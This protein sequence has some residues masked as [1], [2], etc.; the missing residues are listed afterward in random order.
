[1]LD[2]GCSRFL[3]G[4]N[5]LEKWEQIPAQEGQAACASGAWTPL[6]LSKE[7]RRDLGCH[8]D[9]GRG[10]LSFEKLGVRAVVT[11][12]QSPAST[13]A[14]DEFRATKTQDPG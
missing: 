11:S 2:T 6:L 7:F 10:H 14:L 13:F 8:I 5:T 1:M 9:L 12:E 4:Q 3:I